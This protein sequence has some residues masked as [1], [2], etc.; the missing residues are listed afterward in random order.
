M[1]TISLPEFE[2][3]DWDQGNVEKNWLAHEVTHQ[4]A[5]Q[6]FFNRPLVVADDPK[7]SLTEKRYFVLGQTD[8]DRPL[9]IA[10][11]V[12]KRRIRVISARDM[13]KKEKKV[14]LS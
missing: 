11:T 1:E 12:R 3:F 9:F 4:E 10:F 2:G 14:Y 7:H 8:E 6:A 5:E 13:N